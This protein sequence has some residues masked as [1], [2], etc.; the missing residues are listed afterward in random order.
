MDECFNSIELKDLK[1]I[2]ASHSTNESKSK[3]ENSGAS[4]VCKILVIGPSNSGKTSLIECFAKDEPVAGENRRPTIGVDFV[5]RTLR[6]DEKDSATA[7][8]WDLGGQDRFYHISRAFYKEA[9]A[10][11][12]VS[13]GV[14][15]KSLEATIKWKTKLDEYLQMEGRSIPIIL[16]LNKVDLYEV[17][18]RNFMNN[19][20]KENKISGW[21]STSAKRNINVRESFNFLLRQIL[22]NYKQIILEKPK[23]KELPQSKKSPFS[24]KLVLK[25]WTLSSCV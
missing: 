7:H 6:F 24:L 3:R 10:A 20:C 2:S 9:A 15:Q 12:V 1:G 23:S 18:D 5:S 21:F 8:L 17:V 22:E 25:K 11:I 13:D 19:F 4:I 16:L 14:S